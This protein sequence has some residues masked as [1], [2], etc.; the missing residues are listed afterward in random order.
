MDTPNLMDVA[1][2]SNAWLIKGK[3]YI[4]FHWW[5]VGSKIYY[6]GKLFLVQI[7]CIRQ[8]ERARGRQLTWAKACPKEDGA[9]GKNCGF[10]NVLPFPNDMMIRAY[11]WTFKATFV[12]LLVTQSFCFD[13]LLTHFLCLFLGACMNKGNQ[14]VPIYWI[15]CKLDIVI[16]PI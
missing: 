5:L 10:S 6:W 14:W 7:Q 9:M 13:P 16:L 8:V 12:S 2:S 3:F 1:N 11:E 4:Y 15:E